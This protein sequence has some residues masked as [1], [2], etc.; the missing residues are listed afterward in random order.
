MDDLLLRHRFLTMEV[1]LCQD[2]TVGDLLGVIF[3][4]NIIGSWIKLYP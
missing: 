4:K 3:G 2:Q 1:E